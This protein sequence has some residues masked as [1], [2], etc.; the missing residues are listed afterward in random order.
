ME[1]QDGAGGVATAA[2]DQAAQVG[3]TATQAGGQV[4]R[5]TKDQAANVVGEAT[6]QARDLI[7]E[8]R[9]QVGD[10]AGAQKGRAVEGLRSVGDELHQMAAQSDRSGLAT[11]VAR[12]AATRAHGLAD[13]L[14]RHEP[15]ELLDQ[16]RAYARRRPVV[17]LTG[18]AVLGVLAGRLTRNLASDDS[19]PQALTG[20]SATPARVAGYEQDYLAT[21]AGTPAYPAESVSSTSGPYGSGHEPVFGQPAYGP[22]AYEQP[23]YKQP[24]NEE[25]VQPGYAQPGGGFRPVG[26]PDPAHRPAPG[27]DPGARPRPGYQDEADDPAWRNP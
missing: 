11:E 14:D 13:H 7:G 2:K 22:P 10:Q 4:A 21:D 19:G 9:T 24:A 25:P 20:G 6:Q 3:Q 27:Y 1:Q 26:E 12:Q 17:F 8:A 15:T 23:V 18:A 16:V 5:T